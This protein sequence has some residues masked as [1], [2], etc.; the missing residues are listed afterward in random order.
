MDYQKYNPG[1]P[2]RIIISSIDSPFD[3][4]A[5]FLHDIYSNLNNVPK[6]PPIT[7][8]IVFN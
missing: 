1:N 5:A 6:F 4:F 8:R 7:L 2:F 3:F